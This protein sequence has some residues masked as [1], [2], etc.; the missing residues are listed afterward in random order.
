MIRPLPESKQITFG[1][2]LANQTWDFLDPSLNPT[3]LVDVFEYYTSEIINVTFPL[4]QVTIQQSDK[5]YFTEELRNLRRRKMREYERNGKS[6]LFV[7]LQ[8]QFKSIL[9]IEVNKYKDKLIG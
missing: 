4:K 3:Q 1:Q 8:T 5:P 2:I 9:K 7:C 6:D